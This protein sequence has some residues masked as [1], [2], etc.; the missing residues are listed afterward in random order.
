MPPKGHHVQLQLAIKAGL[1]G[2]VDDESSAT[3]DDATRRYPE[4]GQPVRR[5]F[6]GLSR[7]YEDRPRL[8]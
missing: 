7:E 4:L 1:R 5:E 3:G 8:V 2:Q 6:R